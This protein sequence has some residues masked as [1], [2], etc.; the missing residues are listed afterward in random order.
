MTQLKIGK[1]YLIETTSYRIMT[2]PLFLPISKTLES[3][4]RRITIKLQDA[5]IVNK[6]HYY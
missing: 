4:Y 6:T 1:Q 2:L 3:L 5:A